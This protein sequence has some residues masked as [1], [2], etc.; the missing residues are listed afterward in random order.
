MNEMPTRSASASKSTG[1]TSSSTMR[2]DT[3]RGIAAATYRLDSIE[4]R[5]N[6]VA[7]E[8]RLPG[9][10]RHSGAVGLTSRNRKVSAIAGSPRFAAPRRGGTP[11]EPIYAA[12]ARPPRS[13]SRFGD[14]RPRHAIAQRESL[15]PPHVA[16]QHL[17]V[18]V[19]REAHRLE[20]GAF[21]SD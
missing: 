17:P 6:C 20:P 1:S 21:V 8:G 4:K 12:V 11:T 16:G 10:T 14:A 7:R 15:L 3:S 19:E 2:T 5:K 18:A 9:P 13:A